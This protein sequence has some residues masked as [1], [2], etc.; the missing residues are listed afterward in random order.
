MGGAGEGHAEFTLGLAEQDRQLPGLDGDSSAGSSGK[1]DPVYETLR[2]GT[3]LALMNRSSFSSTSESPTRSL[4]W[5]TPREGGGPREW[6]TE[7]SP[8]C[9]PRASGMSSPRMGRAAS[10]AQRRA[11][12]TAV[13]GAGDQGWAR[14]TVGATPCSLTLWPHPASPVF[15]A[16]A[17]SEGSGPEEKSPGQ[18]VRLGWH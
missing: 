18:Q 10:A 16:P 3:S 17:E 13:S 11:L 8:L 7:P 4:V 12:A 2:Y 1:V 5:G 15:T 6:G 9:V 14:S